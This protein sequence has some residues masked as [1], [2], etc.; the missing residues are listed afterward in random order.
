MRAVVAALVALFGILSY[1]TGTSDNPITGE[2]QRVQLTAEQEVELGRKLA[3]QMAAQFGG[4]SSDA[5]LQRVRRVGARIA[6]QSAAART[7]YKF[8]FHLLAD[9]KTVNAFALPGG[10]IFVTEALL[11]LLETEDEVAGV[12]GH[13]VGHVLARHSAE[14]LAKQQLTQHLVGAIA[15]GSG[16]YDAT[17]LAQL[18]GSLVNMKHGRDD[19]LESDTLGLRL[20]REA[21]YDPRAK[22]TVM[23]KLEKASGGSRQPEFAS[24]HPSPANRI[25][26]IRE[27]LEKPQ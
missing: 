16:S 18:A 22:L 20:M 26:R 15:I 13:E 5:S 21:G 4:V 19:E 17:Q 6:K 7:P 25:A 27:Q 8:D 9:R 11:A 23:Q 12:L 2:K 1:C 14:H 24:T 3:P 10:Q